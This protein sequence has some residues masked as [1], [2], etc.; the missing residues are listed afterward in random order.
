MAAKPR[1]GGGGAAVKDIAQSLQWKVEVV[2]K[3]LQPH[4]DGGAVLRY[5]GPAARCV[6]SICSSGTMLK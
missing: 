5:S 6:T 2:F 4:D 1:G 3:F